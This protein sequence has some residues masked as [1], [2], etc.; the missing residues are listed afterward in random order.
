MN[1]YVTCCVLRN[2]KNAL[3]QCHP[4]PKSPKGDLLY[5]LENQMISDYKS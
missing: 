3:Y 5:E 2:H 1:L 4:A